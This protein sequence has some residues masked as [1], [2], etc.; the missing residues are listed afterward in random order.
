MVSLLGRRG[1]GRGL[2]GRGAGGGGLHGRRRR[3]GRRAGGGARGGGARGGSRRLATAVGRKAMGVDG[4]EVFHGFLTVF[5]DFPWFFHDFPSFS[6]SF[7]GFPVSYG[8]PIGLPLGLADI[9]VDRSAG[10][11]VVTLSRDEL[12]GASETPMDDAPGLCLESTHIYI[13]DRYHRYIQYTVIQ[14]TSL[15]YSLMMALG[16]GCSRAWP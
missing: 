1:R 11:C 9:C 2:R 13:Y 14:Y 10:F 5:H 4:N 6:I 12:R 8:F 16:H 15:P 3:R 7:H